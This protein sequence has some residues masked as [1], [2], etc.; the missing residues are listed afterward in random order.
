MFQATWSRLENLPG[1]IHE[2]NRSEVQ[3]VIYG[4][5]AMNENTIIHHHRTRINFTCIRLEFIHSSRIFGAI[6]VNDRDGIMY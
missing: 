4:L 1:S 6:L 5:N 3:G 2:K